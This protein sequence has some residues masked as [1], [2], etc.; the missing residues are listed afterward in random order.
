MNFG[1]REAELIDEMVAAARIGDRTSVWRIVEALVAIE[2]Q[3][4]GGPS[5]LMVAP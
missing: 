4:H 5:A 2:D 3:V 1:K